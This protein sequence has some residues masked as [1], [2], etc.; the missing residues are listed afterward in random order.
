MTLHALN[1]LLATANNCRK[2]PNRS[3]FY[4]L[5]IIFNRV[6]QERIRSV[7]PD[8]ACAEWL[9]R[10]GA[11]VKWINFS[12]HLK[13]YN[14]L[15]SEKNKY[16]IQA[17]DATDS[18]ITH[19][20]FPHFVGCRYIDEIKLV[21]CVYLYDNALPLLSPVKDTLTTLE[22]ADCK[23]ITDQGVR[24]LK[25]L[26][27][28]KTLKLSGMPYLEDKALLRKELTEALPDCAIELK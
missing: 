23:S 16:Y 13:D 25:N 17:V 18:G 8:R 1:R 10:N 26:K 28:L 19:V 11:S 3:F 5:T 21:N 9:L 4:W 15:P 2:I 12:Q 24:S 7:G 22:I 27:N 14:S 6:D 20:G